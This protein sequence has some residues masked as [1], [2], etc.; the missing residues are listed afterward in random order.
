MLREHVQATY[1]KPEEIV[2]TI[3][4]INRAIDIFHY[5]AYTAKEAYERIESGDIQHL[6][7]ALFSRSDEGVK[8]R[9]EKLIVQANT[10]AAIQSSRAILDLF[11]YMVRA[12]LNLKSIPKN[13]CGIGSVSSAL[14]NSELKKLFEDLKNDEDFKYINA[15]TN[16]LKHRIHIP[17]EITVST[18]GG[19]SGVAVRAFE[20][21]GH[22]P[23]KWAEEALTSA[24]NVKNI[25][26]EGGR[27]LNREC[28]LDN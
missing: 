16:V 15:L 8:I 1:K 21:E 4:S 26:I 23:R 10:V 24:F 2:E 7:F 17:F 13:K 3:D 20:Y 6:A 9:E 27:R 11:A 25:V 28:G 12:V 19:K 5:H 14:P 22:Y 18:V